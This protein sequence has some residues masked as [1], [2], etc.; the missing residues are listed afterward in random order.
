MLTLSTTTIGTVSGALFLAFAAT[1]ATAA[2]YDTAYSAISVAQI[3]SGK[4]KKSGY[5]QILIRQALKARDASRP[6][7]E[8]DECMENSEGTGDYIETL[9]ACFCLTTD[10]HS[11]GCG[12]EYEPED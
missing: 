5:S 11:P 2:N 4:P 7:D 6:G 3:I 1:P 8:L 9:G 10:S 12:E